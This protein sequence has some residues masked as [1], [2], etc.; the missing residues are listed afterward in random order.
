MQATHMP[1][2]GK[3]HFLDPADSLFDAMRHLMNPRIALAM[4]CLGYC[5]DAGGSYVY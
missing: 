2:P 3:I 4:R 1:N 5:F